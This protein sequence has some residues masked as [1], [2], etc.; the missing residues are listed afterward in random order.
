MLISGSEND[1]LNNLDILERNGK[2]GILLMKVMGTMQLWLGNDWGWR[3]EKVGKW[4]EICWFLKCRNPVKYTCE[5]RTNMGQKTSQPWGYWHRTYMG[6]KTSQPWGY[7]HRTN[8]GQKTSQPW[9]YWHRT[10]MVTQCQCPGHWWLSES[11]AFFS[12]HT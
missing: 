12:I 4:L 8:M 3:S 9:G 5:Y 2:L 6:Q 11:L 10:N 1:L 7:W